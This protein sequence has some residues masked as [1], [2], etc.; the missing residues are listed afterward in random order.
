[1]LPHPAIQQTFS[2]SFLLS[3]SF[4][5]EL[6]DFVR[7]AGSE[8]LGLDTFSTVPGLYMGYRD[9]N[10]RPRACLNGRNLTN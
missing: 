5:L 7:L 2:F 10:L 8:F 1:M 3:F 4:S 9:L 6:T